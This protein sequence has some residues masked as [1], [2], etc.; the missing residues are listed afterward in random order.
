[1]HNIELNNKQVLNVD[2]DSYVLRG[3]CDVVINVNDNINAKILLI[4]SASNVT[5][6]LGNY[7]NV[8]FDTLVFESK[9]NK[10]VFNLSE[11]AYLLLNYLSN[12][13]SENDLEINLNGYKANAL[14]KYLIVNKNNNSNFNAHINHNAKETTSDITNYGVSLG[15]SRIIF[16]TVGKINKGMA[17][18]VCHQ[19]TRGVINGDHASVLSRPI[20]LIDEYDVKANHGTAIGRLSDREL[21]YLMSRGLTKEESYKLLLSGI[22]NPIIESLWNDDVKEETHTNIYKEI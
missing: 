2:N 4:N 9:K 8:Q 11:N 15:E 6:N 17:K 18:S 7:A 16:D 19:L 14:V 20:L 13:S 22:A 5:V 1:M 10:L 3:D 21:Y 12:L